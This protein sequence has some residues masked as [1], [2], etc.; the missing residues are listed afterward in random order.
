M[1][2][3]ILVIHGDPD[4]RCSLE[5]SMSSWGYDIVTV[6]SGKTG[7]NAALSEYWDLVVISAQMKGYNGID[8]IKVLRDCQPDLR[9]IAV[10][11]RDDQEKHD[12]SGLSA[13]AFGVD[14]V[15]TDSLDLTTLQDAVHAEISKAVTM[16]GPA[17]TG[18][19]SIVFN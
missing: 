12:I 8:I 14:Y 15:L 10:L 7:L 1:K 4:I 17:V 9:V 18:A 2:S 13:G 3:R 6:S 16:V 11:D 19:N 5:K